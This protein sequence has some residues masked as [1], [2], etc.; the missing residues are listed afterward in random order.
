MEPLVIDMPLMVYM[1]VYK[2][3]DAMHLRPWAE[4]AKLGKSMLDDR[5]IITY[6][7]NMTGDNSC[8]QRYCSS[9]S[10]SHLLT[11]LVGGHSDE[12]VMVVALGYVPLE[13]LKRAADS[14]GNIFVN[15][16]NDESP[17]P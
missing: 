2:T 8:G 1:G 16:A 11:D 3:G 15:N 10:L 12:E 4:V 9:A 17:S 6:I 7:R 13:D 14:I 5:S